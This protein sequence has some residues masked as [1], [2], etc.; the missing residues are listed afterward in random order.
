MGIKK[1]KSKKGFTVLEAIISLTLFT[2]IMIPLGSFTLTAIKNTVKSSEKQK[3]M[4]IAQS[5]VEQ[6]KSVDSSNIDKLD[7]KSILN[8]GNSD[9]IDVKKESKN[10]KF[11]G[12]SISGNISGFDIEGNI[13]PNDAYINKDENV[14]NTDFD[15]Y[16]YINNGV[17]IGGISSNIQEANIDIG[18]LNISNSGQITINEGSNGDIKINNTYVSSVNLNKKE[19][20]IKI[21]D[22]KSKSGKIDINLSNQNTNNILSVYCY[23][24][25]GSNL[26]YNDVLGGIS[27]GITRV[28]ENLYN[29]SPNE[30]G[31]NLFNID[32]K[33]LKKDQLIYE[34]NSTKVIKE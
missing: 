5:M 27:S 18:Q 7:D 12:Y 23:K 3:A 8:L 32:I 33:I 6:I 13:I 1:R 21:T 10:N 4:D 11:K 19:F 20:K 28:Y 15:Y 29:K 17:I 2:M 24:N 26:I 22:D 14:G 16:L 25:L 31:S 30:S 34:I 9:S